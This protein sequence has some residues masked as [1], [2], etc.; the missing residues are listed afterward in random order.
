ML[1][2]IQ[3]RSVGAVLTVVGLLLLAQ[4]D[5]SADGSM[6]SSPQ[7]VPGILP[8]GLGGAIDR[9]VQKARAATE[10]FKSADTA[11]AAG[12]KHT[13]HCV[14]KPPEGGMGLHFSNPALLD[15]TLEVEK[16]EVLVYE[17]RADGTYKLNGIEYLVPLSQWKQKEPPMIMGQKLKRAE[18][19]GIWYLHVWIWEPSPSGLFADWNPNVKCPKGD[20]A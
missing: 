18:S 17:R 12:Y 19:L 5:A 4:S 1:R 11:I 6:M 7:S 16:P 8:S 15:V 3:M 2:S 9:D 14:E 20:R 13:D 10:R